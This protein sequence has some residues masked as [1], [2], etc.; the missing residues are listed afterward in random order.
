MLLFFSIQKQKTTDLSTI[1]LTSEKG[2]S[3][4]VWSF[5]TQSARN[6]KERKKQHKH[7]Y[8]LATHMEWLSYT[9]SIYRVILMVISYCITDKIL[10][11]KCACRL[12]TIAIASPHLSGHVVR[13]WHIISIVYCQTAVS[14]VHWPWRYSRLALSYQFEDLDSSRWNLRPILKRVPVTWFKDRATG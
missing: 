4:T 12:A 6:L 10:S 8:K 2:S 5:N 13:Y 11:L 7:V 3:N 14:P 9:F 1:K